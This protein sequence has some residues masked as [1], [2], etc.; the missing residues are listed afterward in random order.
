[1]NFRVELRLKNYEA[2]VSSFSDIYGSP[3]NHMLSNLNLAY[4]HLRLD[5]I[6]GK[7]DWFGGI[8]VLLVGDILQLPPVS[9]GPV[10]DR[11]TNK[12]VSL[13]LGCMTSANIWR[14]PV[15]Y[16][17]LTINERQKKDQVPVFNSM[18][19]EVRCGCPSPNTIQSLLDK[20][21]TIPVVDKFEQLLVSKQ[22]PLCLFPKRK[23]CHDFNTQM[24]SRLGCEVHEIPCI[25]EVNETIGTF[26]WSKKATEKMEKLNSDCNLT[27]SLEAVY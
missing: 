13:K 14:D 20:V 22:S 16:D 5:E 3:P 12:A 26:K 7:D 9:G 21:I 17:E 15:V 18:L 8:N 25:D 11:I 10:F 27:A 6:I 19:Q 2:I 24:L 23:E 4:V 1:M